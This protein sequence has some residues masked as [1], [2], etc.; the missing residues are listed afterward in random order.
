MTNNSR[1]TFHLCRGQNVELSFGNTVA[2]IGG[3]V[4]FPNPGVPHGMLRPSHPKFDMR[5][6]VFSS[7]PIGVTETFQ[8]H[9][10]RRQ[11]KRNAPSLTLNVADTWDFIPEDKGCTFNDA[12]QNMVSEIFQS[13]QYHVAIVFWMIVWGNTHEPTHTCTHSQRMTFCA[14]ADP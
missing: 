8:V 11:Y 9:V 10:T 4:K 14:K 7:Q 1:G 13:Q 6:L 12:Q 5:R 2:L 3:H